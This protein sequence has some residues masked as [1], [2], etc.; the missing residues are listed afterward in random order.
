[1]NEN[2]YVSKKEGIYYIFNSFTST[3]LRD[4][5]LEHLFDYLE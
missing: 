4:E 1:M 5:R 3:F 2:N